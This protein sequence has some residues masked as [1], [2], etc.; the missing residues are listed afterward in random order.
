MEMPVLVRVTLDRHQERQF[1]VR[2]VQKEYKMLNAPGELRLMQASAWW[3]CIIVW[4]KINTAKLVHHTLIHTN[5]AGLVCAAW[6]TV[7]IKVRVRS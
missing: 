7:V 3:L 5:C 4:S 1:L 6:Y 2:T